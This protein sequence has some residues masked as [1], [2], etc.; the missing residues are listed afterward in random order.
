M[1]KRSEYDFT[2]DRLREVAYGEL[3]LVR[4]RFLHRR[5][6]RALEE[7]HARDLEGLSAQLAAHFEAA[8]MAE[9][10]IRH[11]RTA[12]AFHRQRYADAEAALLLRRALALNRNLPETTRRMEQ[13]LELLVRLGAVLVTT[14]GYAMPEVG[15]TYERA[16]VLSRRLKEGTQIFLVLSGVWA[17]HVVRGELE[18][19][20][21][22]S[23]EFLDRAAGVQPGDLTMAGH[24]IMGSSLFQLGR[25]QESRHHMEAALALH[26]GGSQ[27]VLELFA[28]PDIGVF[29]RS[30]LAHLEWHLG[31]PAEA[32]AC[33]EQALAAASQISHPFSRAIALNYAALLHVFRGDSAHTL[34]WA[35]EAVTALPHPPVR[36]LPGNGGDSGRLGPCH[37]G[38]RGRRAAPNARG[39]GTVSLYRSRVTASVLPGT[40]GTSL[41]AHGKHG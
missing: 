34:K 9:D 7:L 6:A 2:H 33:M 15:E 11:Y 35:R 1:A 29:G 28:G 5:V 31:R 24:F 41:R 26:H 22:A 25:L 40:G 17:F 30:Y 3:S 10:A 8:G 13:E 18:H 12:G 14:Q 20:R 4:R 39:P 32:L 23:Q 19:A 37:G 21:E 38:P 16:L 36:L 27:P